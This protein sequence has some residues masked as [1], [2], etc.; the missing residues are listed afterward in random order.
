M[1]DYN[2]ITLTL[3]VGG[4]IIGSDG[5]S[6][7]EIQSWDPG[8]RTRANDYSLSKHLP[9]G[10]LT[11]SREEIATAQLVVRCT[12]L[13]GSIND[14]WSVACEVEAVLGNG[15][16]MWVLAEDFGT[17]TVIYQCFPA[18]SIAILRD[19]PLMAD[20]IL[21]VTATIPRQ[22]APTWTVAP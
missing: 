2:P 15:G 4:L 7:M 18:T 5:A 16:A 11:S 21:L 19:P 3:G 6:N 12:G 17:T 20:G 9:G 8:P 1:T 14:A 22:P 10:A 13:D